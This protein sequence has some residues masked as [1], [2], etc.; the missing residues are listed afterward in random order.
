MVSGQ[1]D[2][3]WF[4]WIQPCNPPKRPQQRSSQVGPLQFQH[5]P[6]LRAQ[7]VM[8]PG[9]PRASRFRLY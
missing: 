8:L 3:D 9:M 6:Q 5:V 4:D 2:L 1:T 7:V